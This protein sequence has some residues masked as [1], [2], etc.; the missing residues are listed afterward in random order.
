MRI[1]PRAD[2]QHELLTH[3]RLD[4]YTHSTFGAGRGTFMLLWPDLDKVP[5][6]PAS[7]SPEAGHGRLILMDTE[8]EHGLYLGNLWI[9]DREARYWAYS[10]RLDMERP[11]DLCPFAIDPFLVRYPGANLESWFIKIASHL[12]YTA[13]CDLQGTIDQIQLGLTAAALTHGIGSPEVGRKF[14]SRILD[15]TLPVGR[16]K[17]PMLSLLKQYASCLYT[18]LLCPTWEGTKFFAEFEADIA[19]ERE[20]WDKVLSSR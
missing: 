4:T 12:I 13:W 14:T 10:I 17:V 5:K 11:D 9:R 3:E 18:R 2:L 15:H 8:A 20:A 1:L 16:S 7:I 19:Q 6:F